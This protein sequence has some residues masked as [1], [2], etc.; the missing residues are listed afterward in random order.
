MSLQTIR[1]SD[2]VSK[3][4]D[5]LAGSEAINEF[6]T[7]KYGKKPEIRVGLNQKQPPTAASCPII[8]IRPGSKLE[9][10]DQ[11]EFIYSISIG[12][13]IVNE[14]ETVNDNVRE[15][16]GIAECDELGQLI[17]TELYC[18]NPSHPVTTVYYDL[19]VVEFFPQ[20]VGE[21]VLEIAVM[22]AIG[23]TLK[24]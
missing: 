12:W 16:N 8:V 17:M 5:A 14:L 23:G 21:M 9:G 24:Y 22:P 4:K 6:C 13:G 19:E 7:T 15:L 1:I 3:W 11:E 10:E 2:I 18:V 20:F